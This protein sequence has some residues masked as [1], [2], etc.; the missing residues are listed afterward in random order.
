MKTNVKN[1][2]LVCANGM[3][4]SLLVQQM[5]DCLKVTKQPYVVKC[6]DVVSAMIEIYNSD[7]VL[8]APQISYVYER[9]KILAKE[10]SVPL[11]IIDI[12]CFRKF[13]G[14]SILKNAIKQL[15]RHDV[16]HPFHILFLTQKG[17]GV[18]IDLILMDMRKIIKNQQLNIKV[19][20]E[21]MQDFLPSECRANV[22]LL[23]SQYSHMKKMILPYLNKHTAFS[24]ITKELSASFNGQLVLDF[25]LKCYAEMI[26]TRKSDIIAQEGEENEINC[27]SR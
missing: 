25:A 6:C 22:V 26:E 13:D 12:E 15:E 20:N 7:I 5:N 2:L 24:I 10:L 14:E 3:S 4:T 18:L 19:V 17:G 21:C 1:I 11:S 27:K 16:E 9:M 8:L 23:E